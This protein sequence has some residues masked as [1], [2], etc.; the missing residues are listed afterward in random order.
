ME[1]A[2]PLK[3]TVVPVVLACEG[4]AAGV[5]AAAAAGL[6]ATGADAGAVATGAAGAQFVDP[7]AVKVTGEQLLC[8][9]VSVW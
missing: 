9:P 1:L 3:A 7:M 5:V 6:L 8:A 4:S 2:A